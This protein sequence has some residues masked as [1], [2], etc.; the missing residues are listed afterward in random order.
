LFTQ[1]RSSA[2]G[3]DV[4]SAE[5]LLP[6]VWDVSSFFESL[7]AHPPVIAGVFLA[8]VAVATVAGGVHAA[9]N[10]PD[11]KKP[12]EDDLGFVMNL[13]LASR[14]ALKGKAIASQLESRWLLTDA[15][16]LDS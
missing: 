13:A 14:P 10:L 7:F 5:G 4:S 16:S 2:L 6:S 1:Q 8:R 12:Q 15:L 3:S 11:V 9:L